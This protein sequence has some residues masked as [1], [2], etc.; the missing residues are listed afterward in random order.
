MFFFCPHHPDKGY[1]GE[2]P[3]LKIDCDCRKPKIGMLKTA[4]KIYNIDF[5]NSWFVGDTTVDVQT[6]RNAGMKT[7]LLKTGEAGLDGK[8]DVKPDF[9]TEN[10]IEA[11]NCILNNS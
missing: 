5:A 2:I 10:L 7:V 8:Y 4:A 1:N 3:A 11:V 6:G 9:E